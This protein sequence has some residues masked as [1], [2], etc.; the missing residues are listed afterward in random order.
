MSENKT[1]GVNGSILAAI[2]LAALGAAFN[3]GRMEQRGDD[4]A[5]AIADT[6]TA[7][8]TLAAAQSIMDREIS[9]RIA[10][11]EVKADKP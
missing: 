6:K 1:F 8:A 3:L 2:F 5:Q 9:E 7:T 4:A 11:V 10:R